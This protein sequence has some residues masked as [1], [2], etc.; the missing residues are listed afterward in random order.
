[1]IYYELENQKLIGKKVETFLNPIKGF[2]VS[3]LLLFTLNKDWSIVINSFK[4]KCLIIPQIDAQRLMARE[5]YIFNEDFMVPTEDSRNLFEQ[6]VKKDNTDKKLDLTTFILAITYSCNL[7]CTYCYQQHTDKLRRENM[8]DEQ[9]TN[10]LDI[11]SKYRMDHP[12]EE[13]HI[14]L[15][16]GEPL[17]YSTE[18]LIDK[19]FD[20]CKKNC[21]KVHITTN[22]T[23]LNYYLKKIIINRSI[24]SVINTTIDSVYCNEKTRTYLKSN[25]QNDD[26]HA[27]TAMEILKCSKTLLNYG[28]SVDISTNID[29]HNKNELAKIHSFFKDSG[30]FEYNNFRWD[31]GRVDDRLFETNYPDILCEADILKELE[32]IAIPD[33]KMHA[34]FIKTGYNI[35]NKIGKLYGQTELRGK[36]NYCWT[37]SAI[38]K[39]FYIDNDLNVYRCTYSVGHR[40]KSLFGFSKENLNKYCLSNRSYLDYEQCFNCNLGGY[41]SG[42]CKLSFE[43]DMNKQ[44]EF[45]K[46]SFRLLVEGVLKPYLKSKVDYL[47]IGE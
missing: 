10:V 6:I 33:P 37:S 17:L 1:M 35:C 20:F 13:I 46:E 45:E 38:D 22:G 5:E 30:F 15:F 41:C 7:R 8:T 2:N 18:N 32:N 12:K 19:V 36:Y 16:G 14:G 25:V 44:C 40:E 21:L 9:L 24:I 11:I 43:T 23:H 34:A 39:V 3:K 42:G 28:V 29:K 27:N 47:D 4:D 26:V 31:I